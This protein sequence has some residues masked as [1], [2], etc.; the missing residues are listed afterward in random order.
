MKFLIA[1]CLIVFL[2][3]DIIHL[4]ESSDPFVLELKQIHI[5]GHPN[6]F[7]PSIIRWQ[8]KLLLS[9]RNISNHKDPYNSS[10]IGLIW[11]DENFNPETP[12]QI[13]VICE[14]D[15]M[16][17]KRAEDARL[18]EVD[19][20]L[21]MV[22]SNNEEEVI[23]KR[24]FR[25]FI[26]EL[27]E[28]NGLFYLVNKDK[29]SQYEGENQN[30]REKNWTP[31]TY[32]NNLLLS[33]SL[34]PHLVFKPLIGTEKCETISSSYKTL[35]EWKWGELR[36]GTQSLQIEDQYLTLFHTAIRM[37]SVESSGKEMLHYFMGAA[38]YKTK[39]PFEMTAI[40]PTPIIGKG[41]FSGK[42]YPPL[43]GSWRGIFPGGFVFDN[44][45]IYVV[46]GRQNYELWIAKL[47]KKGLLDSLIPTEE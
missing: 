20:H 7:N 36:G 24:N 27:K 25:V 21:Y 22:Y 17:C 35:P 11:L 12:P 38:T 31:F 33:Y 43:F 2:N 23:A 13:L 1:L 30:L 9:F 6:A 42:I 14:H 8:G 40:S 29:L 39:P 34:N 47:D 15:S 41:F 44:N 18:I 10:Q 37:S 32:Q 45:Y 5:P 4:E 26:A 19:G 3:A 28:E 16:K 46:Y